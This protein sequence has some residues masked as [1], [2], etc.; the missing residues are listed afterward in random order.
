MRGWQNG[1][2]AVVVCTKAKLCDEL[3][4]D[5]NMIPD[6][7]LKSTGPEWFLLLKNGCRSKS[8]TD[9]GHC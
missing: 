7:E 3:R 4:V 1:F 8:P 2:H 5:W 9:G 6:Q